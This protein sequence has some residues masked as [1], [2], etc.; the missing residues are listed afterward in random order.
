MSSANTKNFRD[1]TRKLITSPEE[2]PNFEDMKPGEEAEFWETHD[3]AE[4]VLEEGPQVRAEVYEALD[5][6]DPV[7]FAGEQRPPTWDSSTSYSP[8]RGAPQNATRSR[9]AVTGRYVKPSSTKRDSSKPVVKKTKK[10]KK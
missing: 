8:R 3:F 5:I 10:S 4:G 9:S 7:H 1:I 6:P 2:I